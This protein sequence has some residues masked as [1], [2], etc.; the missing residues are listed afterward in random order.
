MFTD[1]DADYVDYIRDTVKPSGRDPGQPPS[2]LRMYEYGPFNTN[3]ANDM[4]AFGQLA[5]ALCY[6]LADV[7][8]G[9]HD[10]GNAA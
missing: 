3:S 1:F 9:E 4:K 2:L 8:L 7:G 10:D 6:Q 5:L